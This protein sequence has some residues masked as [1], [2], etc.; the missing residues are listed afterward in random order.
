MPTSDYNVLGS[1][2]DI[3]FK[4]KPKSILDVGCG[5]G[6]YGLLFR[7]YLDI[8]FERFYKEHWLTRIDCVEIYEKYITPIQKYVYN[9]I[10]IGDA[11]QIDFD[12]YDLVFLGDILQCWTLQEG[13]NFL[14][15]LNARFI[16][17]NI[18]TEGM[19]CQA[20]YLENPHER[21]RY[22]WKDEDFEFNK[23]NT[24]WQEKN[25][26]IRII[27]LERKK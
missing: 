8:W 25:Q 17:I 2:L 10:I 11:R 14:D 20:T 9:N 23:W 18:P 4:I 26:K 15:K 24:K 16:L 7:E 21:Q 19:L 12:Y 3:V 5:F 22:I 27:L 13:K 1:V 6:K